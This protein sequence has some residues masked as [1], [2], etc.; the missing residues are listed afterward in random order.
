MDN[1][2]EQ[3]K[4]IES[5]VY[6][7][8]QVCKIESPPQHLVFHYVDALIAGTLTYQKVQDEVLELS[9][10]KSKE[11]EPTEVVRNQSEEKEKIK[12]QIGSTSQST[13]SKLKEYVDQLYITYTGKLGHPSNTNFLVSSLANKSYSYTQAEYFVKLSKEAREFEK[14]KENTS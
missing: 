11:R 7:V 14:K 3:R 12:Q 8:F 9:Q 10:G 5:W 4:Q 6:Q 2:K 1:E 13:S